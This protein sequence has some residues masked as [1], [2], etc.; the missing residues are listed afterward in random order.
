MSIMI[1]LTTVAEAILRTEKIVGPLEIG[2]INE[3]QKDFKKKIETFRRSFGKIPEI[4]SIATTE[5]A[6]L[7]KFLAENKINIEIPELGY[8]R[9]GFAGVMKILVEW[10]TIGKAVTIQS[11]T[12][13]GV[14]DGV[15][16]KDGVIHRKIEGHKFPVTII[17]TKSKDRFFITLPEKAPENDYELALMAEKIHN[18]VLNTEANS[19][20]FL[21]SLVREYDGIGVPMLNA[22]IENEASWILGMMPKRP[23][24]IDMALQKNIF[25]LDEYG[26]F[27]ES[28]FVGSMTLGLSKPR[29]P[30]VIRR[31]FLAWIERNKEIIFA[32]YM[33]E[34]DWA[35]P[36]KTTDQLKK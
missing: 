30:L 24:Y 23:Y 25:M 17:E 33:T 3:E 34:E 19:N 15:L 10:L 14:V 5:S 7:R 6:E 4:K 2:A 1:S 26:A 21:R 36:P 32:G 28:T 27:V 13:K 20:L 16:L 8:P 22:A 12:P 35:R 9:I 18:L 31:P 11:E 29:P